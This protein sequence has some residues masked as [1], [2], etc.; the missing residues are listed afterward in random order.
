MRARAREN[1]SKD[2]GEGKRDLENAW[3]LTRCQGL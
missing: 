2:E 3:G 1:G